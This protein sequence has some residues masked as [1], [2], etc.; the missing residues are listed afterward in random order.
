MKTYNALSKPFTD[1]VKTIMGLGKSIDE[2]FIEVK[3]DITR[4]IDINA[5]G[6]M[7]LNFTLIFLKFINFLLSN[8]NIFII[9]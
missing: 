1:E 8:H 9:Q 4:S 2:A 5:T 3:L 7:I 6:I